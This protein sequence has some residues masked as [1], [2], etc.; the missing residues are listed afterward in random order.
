MK[1]INT[2]EKNWQKQ[3]ADSMKKKEIFNL[4]TDN[5]KLAE[6]LIRG[7]YNKPEILK[8]ILGGSKLGGIGVCG[9][10]GVASLGV[11]SGRVAVVDPELITK[12]ILA[13][14]AGVCFIGGGIFVIILVKMLLSKKYK[15][16]LN[17]RRN[18]SWEI[19]AEPV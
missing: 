11:T 1:T 4:V 8:I 17:I 13:I 9:V 18:N 15:F 12:T 2:S 7:E 14:V 6:G 16:R 19:E 5:E 3:F 10:T